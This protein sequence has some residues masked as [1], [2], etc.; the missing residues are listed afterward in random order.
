M[1]R[2]PG[3]EPGQEQVLRTRES[4]L[5]SHRPPIPLHDPTGFSSLQ[6]VEDVAGICSWTWGGKKGLNYTFAREPAAKHLLLITF[7]PFPRPL[8]RH[9]NFPERKGRWWGRCALVSH[10]G[11][12]EAAGRDSSSGGKC[13]GGDLRDEAK[14]FFTFP[15]EASS[16]PPT[17]AR[18]LWRKV[19]SQKTEKLSIPRY[20]PEFHA[21][22]FPHQPHSG[23]LTRT[24]AHT[25]TQAHAC[26]HPP[27]RRQ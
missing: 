10:S 7:V 4:L 24:R 14:T 17:V 19:L 13:C 3:L 9:S 22:V 5:S 25:H 20:E 23:G 15:K 2:E 21:S 8:E 26:P 12:T 18:G 27:L 1:L 11:G 16:F 6:V